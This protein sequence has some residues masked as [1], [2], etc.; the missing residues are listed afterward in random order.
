MVAE[1]RGSAHCSRAQSMYVKCLTQ[2]RRWG[3]SSV[4]SGR[5][6]EGDTGGRGRRR[7][8]PDLGIP[9]SGATAGS[10]VWDLGGEEDG[11]EGDLEP[12][13]ARNKGCAGCAA[14]TAWGGGWFGRNRWP[15]VR[16][17]GCAGACRR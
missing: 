17:R 14:G 7:A 5:R 12:M 3:S 15:L 16:G 6:S 8:E 11:A 2:E 13:D 10:G 4:N 1:Q 9:L